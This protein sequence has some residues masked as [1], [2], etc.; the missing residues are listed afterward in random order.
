MSQAGVFTT[1]SGVVYRDRKR[2]AWIISLLVPAMIFV[3]PAL[4]FAF[5]HNAAW[6]WAPLAFFYGVIPILDLVMG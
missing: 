6:L 3:G 5:D 2:H 1:D 4:Y